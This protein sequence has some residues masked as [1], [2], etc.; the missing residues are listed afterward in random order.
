VPDGRVWGWGAGFLASSQK[1]ASHTTSLDSNIRNLPKRSTWSTK[2]KRA[3]QRLLS[4]LTRA[5]TLGKKV[6]FMTLT[7]SPRSSWNELNSHFQVLRKRI[8][9]IFGKMDYMKFKTNEGYG[10]LHVVYA[11][12]FVP[13]RWLS[14]NWNEIHGA[15]I[16]DVREVRGENRLARYLISNYLVTQT[17]VRMSW[18]WGWVFRGFVSLW[19]W[20]I[21]KYGYPLCIRHWTSFL[22]SKVL[23]WKQ[24]GL[25]PELGSKAPYPWV[26]DDPRIIYGKF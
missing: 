15:K 24:K 14:R 23:F 10:V 9:R 6:R 22:S 1:R 11:G 5:K 26:S 16:V 4:G 25:F 3:Y 13:Q 18:S 12:S 7:S 2:Q 17:F 19:K 21:R 8:E 20:F